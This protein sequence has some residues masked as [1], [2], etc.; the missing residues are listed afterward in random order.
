MGAQEQRHNN[1]RVVA[2]GAR[3]VTNGTA[4]DESTANRSTKRNMR[5]C[6]F[7]WSP[8]SHPTL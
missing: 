8:G 5:T 6:M 3:H 4:Q 7:R 1:R 2:A